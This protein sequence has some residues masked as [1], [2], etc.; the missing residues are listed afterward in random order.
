MFDTVELDAD[1]AAALDA[2][3]A[4]AV[5]TAETHGGPS[6]F[7]LPDLDLADQG[8]LLAGWADDLP[9][10]LHE[11][12]VAGGAEGWPPEQR[13]SGLA[14]IS[15]REHLAQLVAAQ[16]CPD[17]VRALAGYDPDDLDDDQRIDHLVALGRCSAWLE[18]LQHR[19]LAAMG[20]RSGRLSDDGQ[21]GGER[22]R[23]S[24]SAQHAER[25]VREE[26]GAALGLSPMATERR[27]QTAWALCGDGRARHDH[28]KDADEDDPATPRLPRFLTALAQGAITPA[29]ARI[30]VEQTSALTQTQCS[31]VEARVLERAATQSLTNFTRSMKTAVLA[32]APVPAA[33]RHARARLE[34]RTWVRPLDDGM[35]LLC[36][37]LA[38]EDA[39]AGHAALDARADQAREALR[40]RA[41]E[42]GLDWRDLDPGLAAL[43]ADALAD[44]LRA[45]LAQPGMPLQQGRRPHISVTI[46]LPTLLGLAEHPGQLSGYGPIPAPFA[47]AIAAEGTWRRLVTDPVTGYLLDYARTTYEPPAALRDYL[48]ARDVTS[49]F[50][51]DPRAASR[52]DLDHAQ[53][54][55]AAGTTSAANLGAVSRRAHAAK[56][57]GCWHLHRFPDGTAIWTSPLGR[58][59]PVTPH[60]YDRYD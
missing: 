40:E 56:T 9:A 43:R 13:P 17:V 54:W 20:T 21:T 5:Q 31:L 48:L 2:A 45:V 39:L 36:A 26:V 22:L 8:T 38:A 7:D 34:R 32:A 24:L 57:Q 29:H 58:H 11:L 30:A 15:A 4:F 49:R 33:E 53:E 6:D 46:D 28:V 50:P 55:A 42:A 59:Y 10:E 16:P 3:L 44:T 37:V 35:A 51:Y 18:A 14:P 19:T 52:C 47:R 27:L 1:N 60:E 23:R 12:L 25:W 41:R